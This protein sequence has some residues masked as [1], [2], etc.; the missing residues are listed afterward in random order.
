MCYP[1]NGSVNRKYRNARWMALRWDGETM[2]NGS[3]S[4]LSG[5]NVACTLWLHRYSY[6]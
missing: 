5:G 3:F 4:G 6:G 2:K 1:W